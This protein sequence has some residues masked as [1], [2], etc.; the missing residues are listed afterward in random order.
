MEVATGGITSVPR[1]EARSRATSLNVRY[2]LDG[3]A[4]LVFVVLIGLVFWFIHRYAVNMIY[5]DQWTDIGVIVHAHSGTLTLGTLWAQHNENR[6][7]FPNLIVLAL[8]YTSHFNIVFEDYLSGLFWCGTAAFLIVAHK[9]RSPS[10]SWIVYVPVAL[11]L[12]SFIPVGDTLF[13]AQIGWFIALWGLA[14]ALY[15]LDRPVLATPALVAAIAAGVIGSYSSMEGLFIW[16][17]GLV[18]LYL[19]QRPRAPVIAWIASGLVTGAVYF[20]DY[21]FAAA[22]GNKSYVLHHPLIAVKF[23]VS[24]IGN[25]VGTIYPNSSP[26][27][28]NT[29]V[30]ILGALI[31]AIA[32]WALIRGVRRRQSGGSPIG[33]ALICFGLLFMAVITLGRSQLGL[34]DAERYSI[35]TLTIWVGAYLAL[36]EPTA[37]R[38]EAGERWLSRPWAPKISLAV[39]VALAALMVVQVALGDGP[40]IQSGE[41]WHSVELTIA[42]VTANIN[43]APDSLV[44]QELG[45]YPPAFM[46]QLAVAARSER[47]SL[48]A[49][50]IYTQDARV[51]LFPTLVTQVLVPHEGAAVSGRTVLDASV[52]QIHGMTTLQF[53]VTG[54]SLHDAVVGTGRLTVA[55]WITLWDTTT[56]ANGVYKLQSVLNR[57]GGPPYA[58]APVVVIVDN[59]VPSS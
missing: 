48:F 24:S 18:L 37:Q 30:L 34:V 9:R 42:D 27:T 47:L 49:T 22:G 15:F 45:G 54:G 40:A 38:S 8:A 31:L 33:V 5:Y 28:G 4:V 41:D 7:L 55:G 2:V 23:F 21:D 35:F 3:V 56:V 26:S 10:V 6:I 43:Q 44:A 1:A 52:T 51:G 50:P 17:A 36:L 53:R 57:T 58:S 59:K 11:L 25:V 12:L 32:V 16:P 13:G 46:R 29:N 20:V 14:G 39:L 19:R